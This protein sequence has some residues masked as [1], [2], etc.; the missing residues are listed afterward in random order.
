MLYIVF[1][2]HNKGVLQIEGARRRPVYTIYMPE[3]FG[4]RAHYKQKQ[5]IF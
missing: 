4:K 2:I 1:V 3:N 5:A